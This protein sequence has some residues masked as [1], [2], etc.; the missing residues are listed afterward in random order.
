M[1]QDCKCKQNNENKLKLPEES[2]KRPVSL[3]MVSLRIQ[4]LYFDRTYQDNLVS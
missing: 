2:P 4:I 3:A 1:L